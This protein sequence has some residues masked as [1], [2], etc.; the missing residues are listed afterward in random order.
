[1]GTADLRGRPLVD[2]FLHGAI[3]GLP[4][5]GYQHTKFQ[6]P[7]YITFRDKEGVLEFNVGA[8]SPLPY[9]VL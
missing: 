7:S 1:M 2:K 8:T 3:V 5:N 9:P 6:L 4:A